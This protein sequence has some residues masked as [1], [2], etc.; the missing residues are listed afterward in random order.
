MVS[1]L[2]SRGNEGCILAKGLNGDLGF[3]AQSAWPCCPPVKAFETRIITVSE[4]QLD[5]MRQ[6]PKA[7]RK[8]LLVQNP[9]S[10]ALNTRIGDTG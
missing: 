6:F 3:L 2:A 8:Q 5:Y 1:A 10:S 9:R 7:Q 4:V